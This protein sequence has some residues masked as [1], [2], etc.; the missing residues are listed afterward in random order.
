MLSYLHDRRVL[1]IWCNPFLTFLLYVVP[2]GYYSIIYV[3]SALQ[4]S[5]SKSLLNNVCVLLMEYQIT[6]VLSHGVMGLSSVDSRNG[7]SSLNLSSMFPSIGKR[8]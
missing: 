5:L 2:C 6:P 7:P 4:L 3:Y 8:E 1:C